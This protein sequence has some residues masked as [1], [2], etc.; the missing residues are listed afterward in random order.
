MIIKVEQSP[1]KYKRYRATIKLHDGSMREID[2]GL[3]GG[4]TYIDGNRTNK[5]RENYL[6]RHLANK[7][8][9]TLINK[10][11][12]SPSLLSAYLLWGPSKSLDKNI[13]ELNKL[14]KEKHK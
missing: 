9:N 10:L 2:F 3:K 7:I 6:R 14:W 13:N 12:P 1:L 4:S 11:I 8:E 5:E